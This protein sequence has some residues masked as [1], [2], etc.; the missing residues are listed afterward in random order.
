MERTE[1]E[2]RNL[3]RRGK[4]TDAGAGR[5]RRAVPEEVAKLIAHRPLALETLIGIVEGRV[6]APRV[7][8]AEKPPRLDVAYRG[9]W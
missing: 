2:V 1:R 7:A 8:E 9:L 5:A 4:L 3:F 6:Q